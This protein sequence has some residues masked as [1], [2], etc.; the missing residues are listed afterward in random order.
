MEDKL[1]QLRKFSTTSFAVWP[2]DEKTDISK[3]HADV[4]ILGL[5]PSKDI[6]FGVNFHGKRFDV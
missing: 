5:N 2:F 1:K 6:A 4:V 3:L